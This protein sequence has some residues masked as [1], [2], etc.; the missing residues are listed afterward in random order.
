M[1]ERVVLIGQRDFNAEMAR[2]LNKRVDYSVP[3]K[4][5]KLKETPMPAVDR[6]DEITIES[7][8]ES[9]WS[10]L[11]GAFRRGNEDYGDIDMV[12]REAKPKEES[13]EK[14]ED[15]YVELDAVEDKIE[16]RKERVLSRLFARI[17]FLKRRDLEP[18]DQ[19]PGVDEEVKQVLKITH[20]WLLKLPPEELAQ[21]KA[22]SDFEL[23]KAILGKYRLIK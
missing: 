17:N 2:Y 10:K 5:I 20:K 15:E 23:Y 22:S 21:F 16:A 11:F 4:R 13:L 7:D 1:D 6:E 3:K 18:E 9:F 19:A 14:M 12:N 8:R